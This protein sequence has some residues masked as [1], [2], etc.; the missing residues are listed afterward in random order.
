MGGIRGAFH[1]LMP[2][3]STS[4]KTLTPVAPTVLW[5]A[6]SHTQLTSE[7]MNQIIS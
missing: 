7:H 2:Q 4:Q 3:P 1:Q 5:V 6:F